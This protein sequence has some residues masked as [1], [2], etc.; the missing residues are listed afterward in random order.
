M[1]G[2][3][4]G[5]RLTPEKIIEIHTDI[6]RDFGGEPGIRD[7]ATIEYVV[8][9]LNR[10][11]SIFSKSAIALHGIATG[12]PFIDGNKRTALV[13]AEN[14]LADEGFYLAASEP[15]IVEFNAGG[16]PVHQNG[17]VSAK[18]D[19]RKGTI[20]DGLTAAMQYDAAALFLPDASAHVVSA[21]FPVP[22][23]RL[24]LWYS[25]A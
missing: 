6:I 2:A 20:K 8:Y 22:S 1:A 16:G 9:R 18:L 24:A 7:P 19:K 4:C 25:D 12:H 14:I 10:S 3:D 23:L 5:I 17:T 11:R 15:E 13:L 21:P